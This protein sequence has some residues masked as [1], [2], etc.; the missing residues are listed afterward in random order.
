LNVSSIEDYGCSVG[1]EQPARFL[2]Y[3]QNGVRLYLE[4]LAVQFLALPERLFRPSLLRNIY[5]YGYCRQVTAEF[6][7]LR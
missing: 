3:Q 2:I 7:L 1:C 5:G 6:N 4:Q